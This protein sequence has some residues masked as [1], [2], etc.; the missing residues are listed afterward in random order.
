MWLKNAAK[1]FLISFKFVCKLG[2]EDA[3]RVEEFLVFLRFLQLGQMI[4][5][6]I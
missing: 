5:E 4:D 3:D 2:W 1:I 6:F